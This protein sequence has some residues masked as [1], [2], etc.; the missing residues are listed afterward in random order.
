MKST[1][2]ENRGVVLRTATIVIV[3]I[4]ALGAAC[5]VS[6]FGNSKYTRQQADLSRAAAIAQAG[7][8]QALYDLAYGNAQFGT[9]W[10]PQAYGGGALYMFSVAQQDAQGNQVENTGRLFSVGWYNG[11]WATVEATVWNDSFEIHELYYKAIY[12]GNENG[13]DYALKRKVI[14]S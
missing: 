5:L 6:S 12:A 1:R 13:G 3:A 11:L 9:E 2:R 14:I 8:D 7:V 10:T 4:T